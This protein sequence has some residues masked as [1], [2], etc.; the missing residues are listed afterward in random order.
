MCV[1]SKNLQMGKVSMGCPYIMEFLWELTIFL[2]FFKN[3]DMKTNAF[4][5]ETNEIFICASVNDI[6]ETVQ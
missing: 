4:C 1:Y 2:K 6:L 3:S 5:S